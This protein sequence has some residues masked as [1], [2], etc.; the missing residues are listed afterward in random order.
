MVPKTGPL[1]REE[2]RERR[3][4]LLIQARGLGPGR[5]PQFQKKNINKFKLK[6]TQNTDQLTNKENIMIGGNIKKH[7]PDVESLL[8]IIT[9]GVIS[10]PARVV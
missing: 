7:E 8:L 2:R 4:E 3:H 5:G 1:P 9:N 10:K 6:M